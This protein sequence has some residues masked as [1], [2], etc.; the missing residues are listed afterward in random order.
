MYALCIF[1]VTRLTRLIPRPSVCPRQEGWLSLEATELISK[2]STDAAGCEDLQ[3]SR[4]E[5]RLNMAQNLK[6]LLQFWPMD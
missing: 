6:L 4:S 3:D 1:P 5:E 2:E